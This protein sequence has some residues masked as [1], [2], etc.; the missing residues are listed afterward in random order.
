M[1]IQ[2]SIYNHQNVHLLIISTIQH[3]ISFQNKTIMNYQE[4]AG[5]ASLKQ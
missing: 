1:Q 4:A 3:Q 2:Y 5:P